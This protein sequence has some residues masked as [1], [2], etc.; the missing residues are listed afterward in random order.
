MLVVGAGVAGLSAARA[1]GAAGTR[2][3]LTE[4][5]ALLGGDLLNEPVLEPWRRDAVA[6]LAAMPEVTVI[7]RTTVFGFY[8][9]GVLGAVERVADHLPQ[10]P[11]HTPRQRVWRIPAREVVL[12]TGPHERL[13]AFPGNDRPGV[14]LAGAARGYARR[15]SVRAGEV[16]VLFAT[17]DGA[18][19]AAF[20]MAEAGSRIVA[21]ID[22]RRRLR[23]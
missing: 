10:Q 13:I 1:A 12:A 15:H 7:L 3:I 23:R 19:D 16:A 21:I 17:H 2:V 22:P 6:A 20:A 14:M 18:Y 9:Q 4:Q 5:D 11:P 8:D